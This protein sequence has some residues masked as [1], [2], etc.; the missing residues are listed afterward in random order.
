MCLALWMVFEDSAERWKGLVNQM[1]RMALGVLVAIAGVTVG[2]PLAG[3]VVR[4]V[5]SAGV[6]EP[7]GAAA[8]GGAPTGALSVLLVTLGVP[9]LI[10][11]GAVFLAW[12]TC[13]ALRS[14]GGRAR[15]ALALLVVPMLMPSYLSYSGFGLARAPG[16]WVGEVVNRW[17]SWAN[18]L[19]GQSLAVVGLILWCWPVATIALLGPV[20]R[21]EQEHLDQLRLSGAG[22]WALLVERA[23]MVRGA[24]LSTIGLVWLL[25]LG[26]AV[27]LHLAQIPTL[28]IDLWA[29][30][31]LAPT[32]ASVW[33][34]AW[35]LVVV[36][37]TGSV[38]VAGWIASDE[39]DDARSQGAAGPTRFGWVVPCIAWGVAVVF[40]FVLFVRSLQ[41]GRLL[42]DFWREHAG[43][44]VDSLSVALVVGL[45]LAVLALAA[46]YCAEEARSRRVVMVVLG[47][48]MVGLLLP[49]V[50]VG[51]AVNGMLNHPVLGGVGHWVADSTGAVVIG[52][53]ARFGALGTV[54]GV[55]LSRLEAQSLRD[56]RRLAAGE[57]GMAWLWLA[58]RPQVATLLGLA[59]AGSCLSLHEI[60]ATIHLQPPGYMSLSQVMLDHLH[61][62][63]IQELAAAGLNVLGVGVVLAGV[64]G[65]LLGRIGGGVGAHL[66]R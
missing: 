14:A 43:A 34:S 54:T 7:S 51:N 39:R 19:F 59:L 62:N 32:S 2:V 1:R 40:P 10:A 57:S 6:A 13:W 22:W 24:L 4:L 31:A 3:V 8:P 63:S 64:G 21:V 50:L 27:P 36:S 20:K 18:V 42:G 26:S 16:T 29:R 48:Q 9:L 44:V 55:L 46:W 56:A 11:V 61:M 65:W 41:H 28:A 53:V 45:V 12:P 33:L 30:L 5:W 66:E 52:H 25:M 23:A 58:V 17:P 60:E 47:V 35:P 38:W 37:L 15:A 49:G